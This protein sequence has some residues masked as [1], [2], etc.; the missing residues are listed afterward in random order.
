LSLTAI[1]AICGKFVNPPKLE[2]TINGKTFKVRSEDEVW[3]LLFVHILAF[4]ARLV[5]GGPARRWKVTPEGEL[6]LQL[7]PTVQVFFLFVHWMIECDWA[8]AYPVSGLADG[9]PEVSERPP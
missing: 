2:E 1:H 4:H 5:D 6:F 3:P 7:P 9:L 8:I